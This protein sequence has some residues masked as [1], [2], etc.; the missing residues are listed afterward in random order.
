MSRPT[1]I[2]DG[3]AA[4]ARATL[5]DHEHGAFDRLAGAVLAGTAPDPPKSAT[6]KEAPPAKAG[7]LAKPK[8]PRKPPRRPVINKM[9]RSGFSGR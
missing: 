2:A 1:P 7:A 6:K 4:D 9:E 3:P 8:A 5:P